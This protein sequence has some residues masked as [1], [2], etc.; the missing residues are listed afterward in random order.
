VIALK[1]EGETEYRYLLATDLTWR[2]Q[3]ILQAATWRW[4]V[5]VFL[6]DWQA[7]EGWG[8]LTK[9]RGEEGSSRSLILSLLVDH[10]LLLHPDPTSPV[11][12]QAAHVY[13][14]QSDQPHPGR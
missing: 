13:R 4:L 7:Y 5:E 2:T 14:G 11:G 1:Y 3:D 9:Q 6:P 10:C 8:T 12:T